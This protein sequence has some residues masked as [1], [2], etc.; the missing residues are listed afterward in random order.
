MLGGE[1]PH[2]KAPRGR[3]GGRGGVKSVKKY[4]RAATG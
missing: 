1:L 3:M 2:L 4:I